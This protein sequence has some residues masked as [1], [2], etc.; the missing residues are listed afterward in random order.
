MGSRSKIIV[1][2]TNIICRTD[3][4]YCAGIVAEYPN[5]RTRVTHDVRARTVHTATEKSEHKNAKRWR[6]IKTPACMRSLSFGS[7]STRRETGANLMEFLQYFL[8]QIKT[9]KQTIKIITKIKYKKT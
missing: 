1:R 2:E 9:N 4:I 5:T 8:S 6:M 3:N 7:L